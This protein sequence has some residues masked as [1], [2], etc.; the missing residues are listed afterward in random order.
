MDQFLAEYYNTLGYGDMVKEAMF[1]PTEGEIAEAMGGTKSGPILGR[2]KGRRLRGRNIN[3]QL[4]RSE[5]SPSGR[6]LIFNRADQYKE[7]IGPAPRDQGGAA[8]GT[9]RRAVPKPKKTP[10][11]VPASLMSRMGKRWKGMSRGGKAALIAAAA[12]PVVAGGGYATYRA[13]KNREK[14][15]SDA[16]FDQLV[17]ERA[18]DILYENGLADDH[19]NVVPPD[20]FE[21]EKTAGDFDSIVDSAALELLEANGYPVEWD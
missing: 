2:R 19:G 7:P 9:T 5:S 13:M 6:N 3:Q 18:F 11:E 16:A 17:E 14:R 4:A 12:A 21:Y 1:P 10:A 15:S 20:E 8:A